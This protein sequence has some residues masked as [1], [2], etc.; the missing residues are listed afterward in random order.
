MRAKQTLR[1]VD[2]T[3]G[4]RYNQ[5]VNRL[6]KLRAEKRRLLRARDAALTP[7]RRMELGAAQSAAARTVFMAGMA[8]RGFS[9]AEAVRAWRAA[10]RRA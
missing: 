9:R 3:E 7:T 4:P 2:K 5:G 1:G 6:A 10:A 8:A